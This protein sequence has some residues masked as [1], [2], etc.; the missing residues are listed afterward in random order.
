MQTA[1]HADSMPEFNLSGEP[2]GSAGAALCSVSVSTVT[3]AGTDSADCA[4]LE[5][6]TA[7]SDFAVCYSG[8]GDLYVRASADPGAA[9]GDGTASADF[10][11]WQRVCATFGT[12]ADSGGLVLMFNRFEDGAGACAGAD[13][14]DSEVIDVTRAVYLPIGGAPYSRVQI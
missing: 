1:G 10:S 11:A 6:I 12:G 13:A 3:G 7:T 5:D 8:N 14:G 4:S 9:C 2:Y